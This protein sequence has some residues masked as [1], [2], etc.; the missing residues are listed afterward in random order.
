MPIARAIAAK[1]GFSKSTPVSINPEAFISSATKPSTPLLK[2][3][4]FTGSFI[5]RSV[6]RS[7]ISMAKPPSPDI[8]TTCR[9]G[10]A[11][12]AAGGVDV[13]RWR[14][15]HADGRPD[16]AAT[17]EAAGE[18]RDLQQWRAGLR[19]AGNEGFRIYRDRCRFGESRFC[20]D[21][22][23]NGHSCAAGRG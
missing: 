11:A 20:G 6:I 18:G 16:Y 22:P 21:G 17:D 4:T 14:F 15:R 8:D 12:G 23:C 19:R 2:I 5:C 7:P 3:T 1:S 13:R 9:P 10:V